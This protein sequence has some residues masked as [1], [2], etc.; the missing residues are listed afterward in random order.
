MTVF[1]G[2]IPKA[3]FFSIVQQMVMTS[4]NGA[5]CKR[6]S[7]QSVVRVVFSHHVA[8]RD[9]HLDLLLGFL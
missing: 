2:E 6:I 5:Q 7:C 1:L 9:T 8:P 4:F 3:P